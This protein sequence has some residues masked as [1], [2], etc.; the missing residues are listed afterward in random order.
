M[1]IVCWAE[2]SAGRKVSMPYVTATALTACV[3]AMSPAPVRL[4]CLSPSISPLLLYHFSPVSVL[5]TADHF[6]YLVHTLYF[7]STALSLP[8][9]PP[10]V[11]SQ[12]S[13]ESFIWLA[14]LGHTTCGVRCRGAPGAQT[15]PAALA[16]RAMS[17]G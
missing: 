14:P 12:L 16:F 6:L 11:S 10:T 3:R 4:P 7:Q 2:P 15:W 8:H 17:R 9:C 1:D 5:N 13:A